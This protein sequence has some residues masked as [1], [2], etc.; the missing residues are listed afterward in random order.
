M[1]PRSEW[2]GLSE[3]RVTAHIQQIKVHAGGEEEEV[4]KEYRDKRVVFGNTW[5]GQRNFTDALLQWRVT[6][7]CRQKNRQ[8]QG[9]LRRKPPPQG[10]LYKETLILT[11]HWTGSSQDGFCLPL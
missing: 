10:A 4:W 7:P 5:S 2:N 11:A 6:I 8:G 9:H 1:G 3:C